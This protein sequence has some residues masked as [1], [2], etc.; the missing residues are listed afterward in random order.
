MSSTARR[1]ACRWSRASSRSRPIR[2]AEIPSATA[3]VSTR[4]EAAATAVRCRRDHRES[5]FV[6]GSRN[7]ETGSSASQR[8]TSSASASAVS[9]LPPGSRRIARR[10]IASAGLGMAGSCDRGVG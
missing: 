4:A 1:A 7:A 8:R 5:R 3:E 9:Y 2:T 10:Q 6:Q